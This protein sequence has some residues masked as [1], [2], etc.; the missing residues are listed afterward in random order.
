M[1]K[2]A[3]LPHVKRV[4]SKGR[5]YYY[6][7]TGTVNDAGKPV[8]R[9]LPDLKAHDF[10]DKYAAFKAG[11]TRRAAKASPLLTVAKLV[12]YY[13]SGAEFKRLK[14]GTQRVYAISLRKIEKYFGKAPVDDLQPSDVARLIASMGDK[15]GAAN[16]ALS[17]I[18][19][20]YK[21]GRLKQLV[22]PKTDPV[23]DHKAAATGSHDPWPEAVLAAALKSD[24]PRV[25]LAAH[26]LYYTAQRIGDVCAMTWN[27]VHGDTVDVVQEKTDKPLS[28]SLHSD[29]RA[30]LAAT[31]KRGITILTRTDGGPVSTKTIRDELKAFAATYGVR[32]VPHGLRKNA[33]I[34]LLEAGC[35]IAETASVSGQSFQVVEYYAKMRDQK[36]LSSAA[37]LK[38]EGRG[39]GN[40]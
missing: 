25:K 32:V 37:I 3:D 15:V 21:W 4:R 40:G 38:W 26:L 12:D 29:L 31:P 10:G 35:T 13:E 23:G 24:K 22:Q 34:A 14:P 20:M 9:R 30:L 8:L 33:V 11:R 39:R 17:V 1:P 5:D 7:D 2:G 16:M 6:F 19:A 27:A 36:L 18:A 28:I